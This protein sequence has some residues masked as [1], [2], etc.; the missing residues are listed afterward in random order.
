MAPMIG[1]RH[2]PLIF[3]QIKS[4]QEHKLSENSSPIREDL[5][6]VV[7]GDVRETSSVMLMSMTPHWKKTKEVKNRYSPSNG[8]VEPKFP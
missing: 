5:L 3:L 7:E 8:Y 2:L 6:S 4:N 1:V